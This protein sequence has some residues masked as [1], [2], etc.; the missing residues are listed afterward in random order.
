M[1]F[2]SLADELAGAF[3]NGHDHDQPLSSGLGQS[4]AD[5]FGMDEVYEMNDG[6]AQGDELLP[7][8][9]IDD[10]FLPR[11]ATPPS[12]QNNRLETHTPPTGRREQ[13][14]QIFDREYGYEYEPTNL[15][16]ISPN[17]GI[18][19]D[20]DLKVDSGLNFEN[21]HEHGSPMLDEEQYDD[22]AYHLNPSPT[23][24]GGSGRRIQN[25]ASNRSLRRRISKDE[26]IR[27][28]TSMPIPE[29]TLIILSESLASSSKLL[30]SLRNLENDSLEVN[31]QKHLNRM[32][33]SEK[34]RE[35]WMRHLSIASREAGL[36]SLEDISP[37]EDSG[38][39]STQEN[40][41][42]DESGYSVGW[43]S[44]TLSDGIAAQ[45]LQSDGSRNHSHLE[46]L[47]VISEQ[48]E[49]EAEEA[50][51]LEREEEHIDPYDALL[52]DDPTT[53]SP[54]HSGLLSPMT[55]GSSI[56][57]AFRRSFG[58]DANRPPLLASLKL[59]QME[60]EDLVVLLKRLLE[61]IH[62]A[63]SFGT[64]ISRQMKGIKSSMDT[65]RERENMEQEARRKI[66]GY[67][68]DRLKVGLT[69]SGDTIKG[70]LERECREFE[71]V[72]EGYGRRLDALPR[73]QTWVK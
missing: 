1:A 22:I 11:P 41:D 39:I 34:I 45:Q 62:T 40:E 21:G 49:D 33:D 63:Q 57:T 38:L 16:D 53:S 50:I 61:S 36:G 42:E 69:H 29:E 15:D 27:M 60:T 2:S 64:A 73:G 70:K 54:R 9:D 14:G 71:S 32:V 3:E 72:L 30:T 59:I 31:L 4:L 25:Q 43:F 13:G 58:S 52:E 17:R 6:E 18:D 28:E 19:L 65:M 37:V 56:P 68:Q 44:T 26:M 55:P 24:I 7:N 5:E 67:E 51:G 35:E 46:V 20:S 10:D 66:E 48:D 47:K 8:G 23:K 12:H